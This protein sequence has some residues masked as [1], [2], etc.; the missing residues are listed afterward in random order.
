VEIRTSVGSVRVLR[1]EDAI[2]D[3]VAAF[4]YWSDSESL[5]LAE[6]A[7]A[8]ARDSVSWDRLNVAL[9]KLETGTQQSRQRIAVVRER[10]ER[11]VRRP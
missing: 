4:L 11:A 5:A 1:L 3:R 2:A 9:L 8:A 6:C 10:L 7:A